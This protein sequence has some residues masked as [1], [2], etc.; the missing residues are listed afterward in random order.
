MKLNSQLEE[1][2]ILDIKNTLKTQ[3]IGLSNIQF[4]YSA[5][6]KTMNI[7]A[8]GIE[9]ILQNDEYYDNIEEHLIFADLRWLALMSS[10][11]NKKLKVNFDA[12][13]QVNPDGSMNHEKIHFEISAGIFSQQMEKYQILSSAKTLFSSLIPFRQ[14]IKNVTFKGHQYNLKTIIFTLELDG[15][16]VNSI[17]SQNTVVNQQILSQWLAT[18]DNILDYNK[19]RFKFINKVPIINGRMSTASFQSALC[20]R[21]E[22]K[23]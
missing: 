19:G 14:Y 3:K 9:N 15:Y 6:A 8:Y 20:F 11:I 23:E 17:I 4:K 22:T 13:I 2:Q 16:K 10:E 21:F 7:E 18:L 5:T 1:S 12:N